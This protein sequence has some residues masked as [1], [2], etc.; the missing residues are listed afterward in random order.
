[1]RFPSTNKGV[2]ITGVIAGW[3]ISGAISPLYRAVGSGHTQ[4]WWWVTIVLCI[5]IVSLCALSYYLSLTGLPNL[6]MGLLTPAGGVF[7]AIIHDAL[8][9]Q[10]AFLPMAWK[11]FVILVGLSC[12]GLF[13][14]SLSSRK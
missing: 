6:A 7:T 4:P 13:M 1:M 2:W 14:S 11:T 5:V 10:L 3:I 8:T 12:V 9:E